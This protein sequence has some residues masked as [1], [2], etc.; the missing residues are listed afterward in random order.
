MDT[1]SED[2]VHGD[3][4]VRNGAERDRDALKNHTDSSRL[5]SHT[6]DQDETDDQGIRYVKFT[7][8]ILMCSV[9]HRFFLFSK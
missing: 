1:G 5:S 6:E 9:A 8:I 3:E 4:S 2:D 7:G